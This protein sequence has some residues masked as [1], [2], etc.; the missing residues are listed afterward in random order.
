MSLLETSFEILGIFVP[1]SLRQEYRDDGY[2]DNLVD[3]VAEVQ[4]DLSQPITPRL[5]EF[6]TQKFKGETGITID[7]IEPWLLLSSKRVIRIAYLK[8]NQE[9][10]NTYH[11]ARQETDA[12]RELGYIHKLEKLLKQNWNRNLRGLDEKRIADIGGIY[13]L[14]K[15]GYYD[16]EIR[17]E[18]SQIRAALSH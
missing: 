15:N 11:R 3:Y 5:R 18:N 4:K 17:N 7:L 2:V 14:L 12:L 16:R 8:S 13:G 9:L 6:Y 10:T 1:L